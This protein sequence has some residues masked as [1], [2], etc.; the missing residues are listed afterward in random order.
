MTATH[1]A[2]R[3]LGR[4]E[5]GL[6]ATD[7]CA[8][9]NLVAIVR[10]RGPDISSVLPEVL[11]ALQARHAMLRARI[12][13]SRHVPSFAVGPHR[14]IPL[15][16]VA[17]PHGDAW[18][19]CAEDEM[20]MRFDLGSA[21]LVR[22]TYLNGDE[23][24][25]LIVTSSHIIADGPSMA[26][27]LD[28]LF[29]FMSQ[30][31]SGGRIDADKVLPLGPVPDGAMPQRFRGVSG[32][33]NAA[34]FGLREGVREVEFR[35]GTRGSRRATPRSGSC[36]L[37]ATNLTKDETSALVHEAR[38][39]RVTMA[40]VV[41]AAAGLATLDA[42]YEDR[43][44]PIQVMEWADLRPHLEPPVPPETMGAYISFLRVALKVDSTDG[45]WT[46]ARNVQHRVA[47]ATTGPDRFVVT[48]FA[49]PQARALNRW[50]TGR[51]GTVAT[52]FASGHQVERSYG[53]FDVS[54]VRACVSNP[55]IGAELAV[56][57]GISQGELWFDVPYLDSEVTPSLAHHIGS[58]LHST[59]LG[60]IA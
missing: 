38:E 37:I 19:A 2:S 43:A 27:L 11:S 47:G 14:P 52:S 23:T 56:V 22:V 9:L 42:F 55:P 36:R 10:F 28:E 6:L 7:A 58:A 12:D 17:R 39:H 18:I 34:I 3:R 60:A 20:N 32:A 30:V 24:S 57:A 33:M 15:R 29:A 21:P 44:R 25:E 35:F 4:A 49:G 50:R 41:A 31:I 1:G 48:K 46:T 54:Q 45:L 51:F 26:N 8:P 53:P 13:V 40:S 59:C 16:S 5:R